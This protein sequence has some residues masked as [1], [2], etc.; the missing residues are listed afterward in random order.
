MNILEQLKR[1]PVHHAWTIN[2]IV[3]LTR[4]PIVKVL[5]EIQKLCEEKKIQI[6]GSLYHLTEK[7]WEE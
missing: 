7:A 3:G 5:A 2:D 6:D 4:E 1:D